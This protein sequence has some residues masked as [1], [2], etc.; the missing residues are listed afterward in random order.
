M[1]AKELI[2]KLPEGWQEEFLTL[3]NNGAGDFEVMRDFAIT[4]KAWRLLYNNISDPEFKEVVDYGHALCRA[5]WESEGRKAL[6]DRQFNTRLYDL[7]MQ[8]RFGW[9]ERSESTIT[10]TPLEEADEKAIDERLNAL[11]GQG[12]R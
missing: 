2:G 11:L 3:Y 7:T 10:E 6:R 5:W 1:K 4:P 9:A 8:N 12:D